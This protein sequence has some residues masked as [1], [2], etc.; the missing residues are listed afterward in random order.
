MKMIVFIK[1]RFEKRETRS[2]MLL[3]IR[4]EKYGVDNDVQ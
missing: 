2:R 3:R 1:S 4:V